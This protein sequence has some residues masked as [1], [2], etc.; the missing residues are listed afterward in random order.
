MSLAT[1]KGIQN[2]RGEKERASQ[3]CP[4]QNIC[5]PAEATP[6]RTNKFVKGHKVKKVAKGKKG[7]LMEKK[8]QTARQSTADGREGKKGG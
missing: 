7:G 3:V 1:K 4:K 6:S 5:R 2:I 8:G